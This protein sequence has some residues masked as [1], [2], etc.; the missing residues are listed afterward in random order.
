[1]AENNTDIQVL[2]ARDAA[3]AEQEAALA[4][5]GQAVPAKMLEVDA[6]PAP[7][8]ARLPGRPLVANPAV[9]A[10]M[11]D[12]HARAQAAHHHLRV[13]ALQPAVPAGML[14]FGAANPVLP[15]YHRAA[16]RDMARNIDEMMHAV[17]GAGLPLGAVRP[18]MHANADVPIAGGLYGDD[19][20]NDRAGHMGAG[21]RFGDP[22]GFG[23]QAAAA[24]Q[25][26]IGRA[27]GF[28]AG[29]GVGRAQQPGAYPGPPLG[30][31]ENGLGG[32]EG[33]AAA[34]VR[35]QADRERRNDMA[36][37][38]LGAVRR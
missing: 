30:V 16:R 28:G 24:A 34:R 38:V 1:M 29:H 15:V 23:L 32:R 12:L 37:Q 19:D 10:Q 25:A 22:I 2:A 35:L 13:Q 33:D 18:G 26:G 6:P 20:G 3:R 21:F 36:G 5:D 11:A 4:A 27:F 9:A 14:G 8:P 7:P 17:A 31:P